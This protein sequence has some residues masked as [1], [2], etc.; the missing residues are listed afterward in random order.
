MAL[1]TEATAV[2]SPQIAY[3]S[4]QDNLCLK[5]FVIFVI[6]SVY[7]DVNYMNWP[8]IMCSIVGATILTNGIE[9]SIRKPG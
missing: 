8:I 6:A 3:W 2:G 9:F 7:V 5:L 1:V 4:G